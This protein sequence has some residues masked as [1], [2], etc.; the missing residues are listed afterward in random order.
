MF[1][2][3][4]DTGAA[5]QIATRLN[6][7]GAFSEL[8][9]KTINL[10]TNLKGKIKNIGRGANAQQIFIEDEKSISDEDL[11]ALRRL[12]RELDQNS[13]PYS[14]IVLPDAQRGGTYDVTTMRPA[15]QFQAKILPEQTPGRGLRRITPPGGVAVV[16]VV[17]HPS[18]QS[19]PTELPEG[20]P[21]RWLTM[22]YR[23]PRCQYAMKP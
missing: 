20:C 15:I 8:N 7:D 22:R 19:L 3:C 18:L 9:G 21:S 14:C 5:D 11:K 17:D 6:T 10:H 12:S 16:T 23:E 13:S 2:M 1:V 4:E